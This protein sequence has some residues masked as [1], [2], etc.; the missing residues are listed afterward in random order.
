MARRS[1]QGVQPLIGLMREIGQKYGGKTPAQVALNWLICKGAIP[2]PGIK[3]LHQAEENVAA[4]GWRL[5]KEEVT[6]LDETKVN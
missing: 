6:V 1:V 4:L 3:N 2:I 5:S